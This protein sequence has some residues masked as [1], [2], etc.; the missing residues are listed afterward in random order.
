MKLQ[1]YIFTVWLLINCSVCVYTGDVMC[2]LRT[3][4]PRSLIFNVTSSA[5]DF[6]QN[7]FIFNTNEL[8]Y[9]FSA[10][11]LVFLTF[12]FQGQIKMNLERMQKNH[13]GT[14]RSVL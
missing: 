12:N 9:R 11:S 10:K 8:H 4:R 1:I 3:A 6:Q 5:T 2:T 14:I 7:C 13:Y